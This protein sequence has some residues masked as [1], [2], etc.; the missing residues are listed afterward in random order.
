LKKRDIGPVIYV[1]W[2]GRH[3]SLIEKRAGKPNHNRENNNCKQLIG[4]GYIKNIIYN[5]HEYKL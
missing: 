1:A 2:R 4:N 3:K 5:K